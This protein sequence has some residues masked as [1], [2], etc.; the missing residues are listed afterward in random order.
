MSP[1]F[2]C[3]HLAIYKYKWCWKKVKLS[4]KWPY[5]ADLSKQLNTL[6]IQTVTVWPYYLLE[7]LTASWRGKYRINKRRKRIAAKQRNV[8]SFIWREW[9]SGGICI[10]SFAWRP[11]LEESCLRFLFVCLLQ[12]GSHPDRRKVVF[13]ISNRF[14]TQDTHT[15]THTH[16][17]SKKKL[18]H[19]SLYH[20][21]RN[22]LSQEVT[23]PSK[24]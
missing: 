2:V 19:W 12:T 10:T 13:R 4:D 1:H 7:R 8:F 5:T 23:F 9:P 18:L 11:E 22:N 15:H 14:S 24:L 3:L 16:N 17:R 6:S 21:R 20:G